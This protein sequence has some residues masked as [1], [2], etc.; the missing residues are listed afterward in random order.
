[1]TKR[2]D[3]AVLLNP[4]ARAL[5]STHAILS[6]RSVPYL[7]DAFPGP[8][9]IKWMVA[10]WGVWTTASGTYRIDPGCY[11]VLNHGREYSLTIETREPRESFCPFFAAGFVGD[12]QR[13]VTAPCRRYWTT[14]PLARDGA[15]T[16]SCPSTCG[17][18][19]AG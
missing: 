1:M 8:L 10:G 3:R 6:T 18:P 15:R 19:T 17:R 13:A 9:S 12:V 2:Q 14:G 11:L 7:V 16:R 4:P 5:G